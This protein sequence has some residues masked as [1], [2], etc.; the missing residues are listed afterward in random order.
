M[1][2]DIISIIVPIYNSELYI[3]ECIKSLINQTYNNIEI[4]LVN[5][6]SIDKSIDICN[7][8][9]KTDDR[10]Q[11]INNEE[12]M[13]VSFSRNKGLDIASGS[14][15]MFLD[16]DDYFDSDYIERMYNSVIKNKC[17]MGVSGFRCFS[18]N[19]EEI[20]EYLDCD[21]VLTFDVI[22]KDFVSTH[23]FNSVSKT[24]MDLDIIKK[25]NIRFDTSLTFFEDQ[26]FSFMVMNKCGRIMYL[27]NCY[28]NYRTNDNSST[29]NMD[30]NKVCKW[31]DDNNSVIDFMISNTNGLDINYNNIRLSKLK[32]TL[33]ILAKMK[34]QTYKKF[35]TASKEIMDKFNNLVDID[36][37]SLKEMDYENSLNKFRMKLI[38]KN[39]LRLFYYSVLLSEKIKQ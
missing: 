18:N 16:S 30:F 14:Y 26:K 27:S 19:K 34:N 24:I 21:K 22:A 35:K 28:Y 2:K 5:D 39:H 7:E 23:Y 3:E 10:I 36:S 6:C 12:N 38:L 20:I 4:I 13:G 15:V 1:E 32:A 9:K 8:Y 37:I 31:F 17:E 11:I 29:R 25:N 33:C